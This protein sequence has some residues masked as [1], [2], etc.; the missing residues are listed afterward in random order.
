MRKAGPRATNP[1]AEL[2]G[3]PDPPCPAPFPTPGEAGEARDPV[4]LR[5]P[6]SGL[7]RGRNWFQNRIAQRSEQS[8]SGN[9]S[10]LAQALIL[11]LTCYL[12]WTK[13]TF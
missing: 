8:R 11:S 10:A 5:D 12:S 9:L 4:A 1:W 3:S 13:A 6:V 7:R 2:Y